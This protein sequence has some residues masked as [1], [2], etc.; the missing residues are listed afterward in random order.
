MTKGINSSFLCFKCVKIFM[1][2]TLVLQ[3][4]KQLENWFYTE[5][6]YLGKINEVSYRVFHLISL[7]I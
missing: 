5:T 1:Q 7:D 6:W 4:F 2:T 3:M